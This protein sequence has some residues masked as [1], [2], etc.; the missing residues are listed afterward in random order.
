MFQPKLEQNGVTKISFDRK[1][2]MLLSTQGRPC[3]L[4]VTKG[5]RSP[6]L[7]PFLVTSP[8]TLG[9][10]TLGHCPPC[11]IS[12][13]G[14][15]VRA[16]EDSIEDVCNTPTQ[17]RSQGLMEFRLGHLATQAPGYGCPLPSPAL[18]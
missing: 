10:F 18:G 4:E 7:P 9:M 16:L 14:M 1:D 15:T 6:G 5:H 2:I 3:G 12:M 11:L 17:R 8:V 13:M